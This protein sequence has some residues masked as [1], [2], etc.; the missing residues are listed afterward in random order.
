SCANAAVAAA[1]SSRT[2][3]SLI[4]AFTGS[5]LG[6]RAVS[7]VGSERGFAARRQWPA[8]Q[9]EI[10]RNSELHMIS[11]LAP[12]K[13][14]QNAPAIGPVFGGNSI[15]YSQASGGG[16]RP[17]GVPAGDRLSRPAERTR[18]GAGKSFGGR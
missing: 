2:A 10:S 7:L 17:L 6:Q 18:T 12:H 16:F 11:R 13:P 5:P 4:N 1:G 15:T 3:V 14:P 9:R 8:G